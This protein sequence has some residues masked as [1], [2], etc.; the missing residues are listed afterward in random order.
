MAIQEIMDILREKFGAQ[1]P[2]FTTDPKTGQIIAT[3]TMPKT[4]L[5][6]EM[7]GRFGAGFFLTPEQ[8][9]R[10]QAEERL[11]TLRER[12]RE[13]PESMSIWPF[14]EA[15]RALEEKPPEPFYQPVT[16]PKAEEPGTELSA[17]WILPEGALSGDRFISREA[18]PSDYERQMAYR[19][20]L[21]SAGRPSISRLSPQTYWPESAFE[22]PTYTT[23]STTA[24][25][26]PRTPQQIP[27]FGGTTDYSTGRWQTPATGYQV[28][29]YGRFDPA[30]K[31]APETIGQARRRP[32][33]RAPQPSPQ[34]AQALMQY[35]SPLQQFYG[36]QIRSQN[37][38]TGL[39]WLRGAP[40]G[41]MP[42]R[43][44]IF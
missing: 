15:G 44:P 12:F 43:F 34:E 5:P 20:G 22:I 10:Q 33:I 3:K 4:E 29:T 31:V 30:R 24:L 1:P 40:S 6:E 21:T 2:Q 26:F 9:M 18:P 16:Y 32:I 41:W 19:M 38:A 7:A 27:V 13:H 8:S 28:P 36:N 42:N 11:E 25:G 17:R 23:P 14:L 39:N 37:Y 35:Q